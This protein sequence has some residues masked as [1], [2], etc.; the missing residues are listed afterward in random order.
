ML[1]HLDHLSISKRDADCY[2]VYHQPSR[3]P[4]KPGEKKVGTH[5]VAA[6][7]SEFTE[8]AQGRRT[9]IPGTWHIRW[10]HKYEGEDRFANDISR[11]GREAALP[12]RPRRVRLLL[13]AG[14]RLS[15]PIPKMARPWFRANS[16]ASAIGAILLSAEDMGVRDRPEGERRLGRFVLP[17]FQR[18]AVWTEAQKVRFIESIWGGLPLG[19][20]VYNQPTRFHSPFDQWLLDGQQRVGAIHRVRGRRLPGRRL[21]LERTHHRGPARVQ[22]DAL[23]L[24]GDADRGR[25]AAS[26]NL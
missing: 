18:P 9:M 11:G 5:R 16:M 14:A 19:S 15:D 26:R 12:D 17:P 13:L 23:R 10:E 3:V 21:S 24:Y 20:Y 6:I 1:L 4:A 2:D 8:D 22:D 7:R 25:G